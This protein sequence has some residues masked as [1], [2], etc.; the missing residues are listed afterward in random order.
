[1]D[2]DAIN[3]RLAANRQARRDAAIASGQMVSALTR[4]DWDF[5][6]GIIDDIIESGNGAASGDAPATPGPAGTAEPIDEP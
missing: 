3:D 1:M 2:F 5:F 6:D 4:Q